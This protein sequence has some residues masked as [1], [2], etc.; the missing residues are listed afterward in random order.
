ME[1]AIRNMQG[2]SIGQAMLDDAVFAVAMNEAV[3]HQALVAQQAN[4]RQGTAATKSRSF[5]QGGGRKPR[6]QKHTGRSRQGSIRSQGEA[7]A[8]FWAASPRLS[9]GAE[10]ED[11]QAGY[12]LLAVGQ[13]C[14]RAT[15]PRR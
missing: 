1:I 5:V 12:S 8:S 6:S 13:G 9:A 4:Q 14:Q 7:A 2:E 10:Q 3:V 15:R 11:A